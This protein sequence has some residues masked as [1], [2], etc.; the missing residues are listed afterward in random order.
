[1]TQE[2]DVVFSYSRAQAIADGVLRDVTVVAQEA[3]F[4]YPVALTAAAWADSVAWRAGDGS[5]QSEAG[6][7]WDVLH[8]ARLAVKRAA[9]RVVQLTVL[10]VPQRGASS[11]PQP[12][13]LK[14][15]VGPGDALEPVITIM[16][17]G[18]D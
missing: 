5:G 4:R 1:V 16:L 18:E 10:V 7:L 13:R 8:M 17:P 9:G 6:R 14:M 12:M 3:G 2:S 15:V 11:T